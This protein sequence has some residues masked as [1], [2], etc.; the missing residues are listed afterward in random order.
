MLR[1]L[2][3]Y[4]AAALAFTVSLAAQQWASWRLA[5]RPCPH[6][7]VQMSDGPVCAACGKTWIWR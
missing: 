3:E 2:A 6:W 1:R 7:M 4:A 5:R